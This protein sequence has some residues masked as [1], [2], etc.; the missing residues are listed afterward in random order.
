VLIETDFVV[1]QILGVVAQYWFLRFADSTGAVWNG[2][3]GRIAVRPSSL[4]RRENL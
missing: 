2:K 1:A 4:P 3:E